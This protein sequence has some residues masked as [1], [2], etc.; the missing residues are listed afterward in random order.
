MA[1]P[2]DER[3]R[4][5]YEQLLN[6]AEKEEQAI[7]AENLD[8]LEACMRRKEE[9][10]KKLRE[11]ESKNGRHVASEMSEEA[12]GL[13]AQVA[14]R[15]ERARERVAAM[16]SECRQAL[17]EIR[18]GRQAHRAYSRARKEQPERSGRLL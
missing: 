14:E 18:T 6:L 5:L 12:A 2:L 17:L 13:L 9:V 4:L 7:T 15:H 3:L 1:M 10:F 16:L 11:I 8:E